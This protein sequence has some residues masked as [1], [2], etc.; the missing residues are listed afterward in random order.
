MSKDH[1]PLASPRVNA[2]LKR[3]PLTVSPETDISLHI[4]T[5]FGLRVNP[6]NPD[7]ETLDIQDIAWALSRI[8]RFAGHTITSIPYNV[9]QHSVYVSQ[10]VKD[11]LNDDCTF[12]IPQAIQDAI[13]TVKI[14]DIG[15]PLILKALLHDA[16]EAFIG[17][18]PSP[19]K[20]IPEV[21]E[22]FSLLEAKLDHAIY[23]KFGLEENCKEEKDIIK[24]ADMIALAV[25]AYQFM[26]SRGKDW[27]VPE[28]S[29]LTIQNF[30]TPKPSLESFKDFISA[31]EIYK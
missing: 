25:E 13:H 16:H 8:S 12:P 21:K 14:L 24:F 7:V 18:I 17:D 20:R 6:T 29:L 31:F 9:A 28:I 19:V 10:I 26:P 11:L 27:G 15:K 30:P 23:T 4:E 22:T 2:A 1:S 5:V 3:K